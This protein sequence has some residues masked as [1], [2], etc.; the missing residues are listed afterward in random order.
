VSNVYSS[1]YEPITRLQSVTWHRWIYPTLTPAMQSGTRFTFPEGWEAELTWVIGYIPRLFTWPL[2]FIFLKLHLVRLSWAL[3]SNALQVILNC[4]FIVTI[5][6]FINS[7][8]QLGVT[9]VRRCEA[10]DWW[11]LI[12]LSAGRWF[13]KAGCQYETSAYCEVALGNAGLCWLLRIWF[14]SKM[15]RW[16]LSC[17]LVS[18]ISALLSSSLCFL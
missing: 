13:V 5:C 3:F 10:F 8:S 16:V 17:I 12:V 7:C 15:I 2:V 9:E 18:R 1:S 4:L 6:I 14:G 11:M